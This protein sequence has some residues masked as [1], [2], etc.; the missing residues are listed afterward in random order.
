MNVKN[1]KGDSEIVD[2]ELDS[3]QGSASHLSFG[4]NLTFEP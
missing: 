1:Q 2:P 3:G 4:F